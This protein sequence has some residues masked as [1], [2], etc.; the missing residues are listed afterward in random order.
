MRTL[1][2]LTKLFTL[3][4]ICIV[5]TSCNNDDGE[6]DTRDEILGI[7]TYTRTG[8]IVTTAIGE[9]PKSNAINET[10]LMEIRKKEYDNSTTAIELVYVD[11]TGFW[12]GN[13]SNGIYSNGKLFLETGNP[14]KTSTITS[15]G[16]SHTYVT[17]EEIVYS[18]ATLQN[19]GFTIS[20]TTTGTEKKDGSPY[21]TISGNEELKLVKK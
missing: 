6:K 18:E 13:V 1:I 5:A 17:Q 11:E 14:I 7:Y 4:I 3:L 16:V 21:L 12:K 20:I 10:G 2:N 9:E 15:N 8:T 19:N